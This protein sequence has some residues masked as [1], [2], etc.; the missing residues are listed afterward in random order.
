MSRELLLLRIGAGARLTRLLNDVRQEIPLR[1]IAAG[2][3][4]AV[5][6]TGFAAVRV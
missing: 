5:A 4:A 3:L 6:A 1:E 2:E